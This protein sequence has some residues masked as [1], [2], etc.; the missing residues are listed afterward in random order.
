M[1]RIMHAS[2]GGAKGM[3]DIVKG[4]NW[5]DSNIE[6]LHRIIERIA[7]YNDMKIA[8]H[9]IICWDGTFEGAKR[10][11][12]HSPCQKKWAIQMGFIEEKDIPEASESN[13]C[14]FCGSTDAD[15]KKKS[16]AVAAYVFC[17]KCGAN[18]SMERIKKTQCARLLADLRAIVEEYKDLFERKEKSTT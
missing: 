7:N 10:Y 8:H 1:E 9:F 4:P 3:I 15:P 5:S 6:L 18:V 14:S 12:S 17:P 16:L 13:I 11:L 2:K